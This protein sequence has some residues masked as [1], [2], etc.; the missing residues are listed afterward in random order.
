[1][2][3]SILYGV[4]G[5]STMVLLLHIGNVRSPSALRLLQSALQ[6][7]C[8]GIMTA[9]RS[10]HKKKAVIQVVIP[11]TGCYTSSHQ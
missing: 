10:P 11:R 5:S 3:Y 9:P 6:E 2:E 1:M 7:P 4:V 8:S